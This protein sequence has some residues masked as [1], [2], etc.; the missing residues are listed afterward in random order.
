MSLF[1]SL[2]RNCKFCYAEKD[3]IQILMIHFKNE[4]ESQLELILKYNNEAYIFFQA[5]KTIS[6]E[7]KLFESSQKN[8]YFLN[9]M[10]ITL[11][12]IFA[13]HHLSCKQVI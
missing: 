5:N 1:T 8:V 13:F 11:V 6:K 7:Q 9:K 2:V 3:N 4:R 12:L 10:L